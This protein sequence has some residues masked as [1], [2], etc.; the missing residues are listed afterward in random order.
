MRKRHDTRT[1]ERDQAETTRKR[2]EEPL[3]MSTRRSNVRGTDHL[4]W[5]YSSSRNHLGLLLYLSVGQ[6]TTERSGKGQEGEIVGDGS[7]SEET[8]GGEQLRRRG[9]VERERTS[10]VQF[11]GG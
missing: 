10:A 8:A 1:W 5:K 2:K 7:D 3:E 4:L 6:A 11:V 9:E